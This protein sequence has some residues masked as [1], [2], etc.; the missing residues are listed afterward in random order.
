MDLLSLYYIFFL[1]AQEEL[2]P[3]TSLHLLFSFGF[4]FVYT[5]SIKAELENEVQ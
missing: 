5:L 2:T 4:L 1:H 3:N